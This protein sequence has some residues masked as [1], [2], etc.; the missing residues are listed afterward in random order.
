M[1][2]SSVMVLEGLKGVFLILKGRFALKN[3]III[4]ISFILTLVLTQE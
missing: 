3:F 1:A 2:Y 4:I